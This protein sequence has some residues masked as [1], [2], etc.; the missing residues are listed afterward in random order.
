MPILSIP[1]YQRVTLG[2]ACVNKVTTECVIQHRMS[3]VRVRACVWF[4]LPCTGRGR[5]HR[6][7]WKGQQWAGRGWRR[8]RCSASPRRACSCR[9]RTCTEHRRRT[10]ALMAQTQLQLYLHRTS[11]KTPRSSKLFPRADVSSRNIRLNSF[12][13]SRERRETFTATRFVSSTSSW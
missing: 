7:G 12:I 3:C 8:W 13:L 5:R 2:E 11:G 10:G 6:K 9:G 1:K 4:C